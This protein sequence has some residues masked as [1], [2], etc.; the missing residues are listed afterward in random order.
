MI[1]EPDNGMAIGA[2]EQ[3]LPSHEVAPDKMLAIGRLSIVLQWK[4]RSF[5]DFTTGPMMYTPIVRG[6]PYVSM[7][8][9]D[10]TPRIYVQRSINGDIIVDN[11]SD[12]PEQIHVCGEGLNQF[13]KTPFLVKKELKIHF[14][15]SDMTW[16]V[17]VS[18]PTEFVCSNL[19]YSTGT[20]NDR[21]PTSRRPG[22]G[23]EGREPHFDLRAVRPMRKGMIRIALANNCTTGTMNAQCTNQFE[24]FHLTHFDVFLYM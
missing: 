22:T 24:K 1:E 7:V 16:I 17:F 14:E 5:R 18:E 10:A 21:E 6:S 13:S 15:K 4:S 23:W 11:E 3:F 12:G 2:V 8:Y 9:S 20:E 19:R